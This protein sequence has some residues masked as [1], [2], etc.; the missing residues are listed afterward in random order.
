MLMGITRCC[1]E[2]STRCV[3]ECVIVVGLCCS[4]N[5]NLRNEPS[6]GKVLPVLK[7]LNMM[8]HRLLLLLTTHSYTA[9]TARPVLRERCT[10]DALKVGL[11][12]SHVFSI[13][14]VSEHFGIFFGVFFVFRRRRKNRCA[15]RGAEQQLAAV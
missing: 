11:H 3:V 14:P 5:S 2:F 13:T 9:H 1:R 7:S 12:R 10:K 6:R 15:P 8:L 4:L